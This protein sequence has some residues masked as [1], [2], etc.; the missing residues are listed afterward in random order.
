M[1]A[2]GPQPQKQDDLKASAQP[3]A[4]PSPAATTHDIIPVWLIITIF[5]VILS[6]TTYLLHSNWTG[7][8][9]RYQSLRS[10]QK[11]DFPKAVAK[12]KQLIEIGE[13]ENDPLRAKSPTYFSELGYSY[14]RMEDYDNSLKYYNLAQQN[15]ANNGTDD[16]NNPRPPLDFSN[17]I[18]LVQMK[19]G[20]LDEAQTTL[21]AALKYNKVDPVANF[22]LGEIA[23]QKG[24]YITAA[25][26]FK[27][28]A[29]NPAYADQVKKYYA[30]I[31]E[32]LFA[33]I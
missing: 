1:S 25:D 29:N 7:D 16:N 9:A 27:V 24:D 5:A 30:T 18:G 26:H 19:Q 6:V 15:R 13:K 14:M 8:M 20:R 10:Q 22:A 17:M 12:L 11:G 4:A 32:K 33:G 31:E 28:V 21:Q 3:S 23:M 2:P